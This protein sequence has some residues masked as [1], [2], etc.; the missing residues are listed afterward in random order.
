MK[1][2]SALLI[3]IGIVALLFIGTV[4]YGILTPNN[5]YQHHTG[6]GESIDISPDDEHLAFSYYK[7][8]EQSIY[9]GNLENGSTEEVVPSGT[10]QNSHPEFSPDGKGMIYFA[11]QEDG[12]N[13]LHYLP[14]PGEEPIQLTSDD[15]H[16][17]E[18]IISPDGNTV[19]YI[20]MPSAD[21][22]QPPGKQ[23]NGSDIH[24]VDIDSDSHEK[25]TDKDAYDMRGL[26]MSQDGE[27][28]YYA[29]SDAGEVMTSYDIETGEEAEYHVSDLPD[30]VS[31]P[32]LSQN[33]AQLAYVAQDGE[34]ENGTFIYEL[35][36]MNTES[37][38]T[39]QL[40][41]Y[42]ASVASP[43]FFTHTNRLALLAEEDWPSEPSE[44]ELMTVSENGGDL[45]SIDLALPQDGNG[46]GFWAF[47]DRMVNAVTLSV[48][49]LLMFGLS[50]AYMH[51]RSRTYLPVI[52]SAVVA[53]LTIVGAIIAVASN[54]WMAIGLTTL[55]IWLGGFTLIL[56]IFAFAYRRMAGE[57]I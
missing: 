55:A 31:Q 50:I 6:L 51:M 14:A 19:Y 21:F 25:L 22:N 35:F 48:L 26:N 29:G 34:N 36:L 15:M 45:T 28:L 10:A 23:D 4:S 7:D 54:P 37:G 53:G 39:E 30:Y 46:I 2:R 57:A 44:F 8:G 20:A 11:S 16:V 52:I 24:R 13:I 3:L 41:D 49:Y 18:A 9:L 12:V 1:K 5:A 33:G 56:W 32:T 38:E 27:T 40:T 17:F 42:G 47:I 43:A